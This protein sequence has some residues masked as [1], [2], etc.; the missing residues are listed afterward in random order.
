[1]TN[2]WSGWVWKTQRTQRTAE[3]H[4]EYNPAELER[5]KYDSPSFCVGMTRKKKSKTMKQ[6]NRSTEGKEWVQEDSGELSAKSVESK[7][8]NFIGKYQ[9]GENDGFDEDRAF[10]SFSLRCSPEPTLCPPW[11]DLEFC[12]FLP[13]QIDEKPFSFQLCGSLCPLCFFRSD[14]VIWNRYWETTFETPWNGYS[15]NAFRP[16]GVTHT[17][18]VWRRGWFAHLPSADT[19]PGHRRSGRGKVEIGTQ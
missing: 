13:T 16:S 6:P 7:V 18:S 8:L 17:Q 3:G 14:T 15:E 4:R 12:D 5:K 11:N 1:M 19:I 10:C 2:F 9:I